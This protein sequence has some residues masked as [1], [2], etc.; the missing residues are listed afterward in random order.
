MTMWQTLSFPCS[1]CKQ[2]G[3]VYVSTTKQTI[4]ES[5]NCK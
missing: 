2:T 1:D 3:Y 4:V 5:C